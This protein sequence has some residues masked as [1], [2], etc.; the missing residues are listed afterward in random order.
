M[1]NEKQ[2]LLGIFCDI[3]ASK[4]AEI[5]LKESNDLKDSMLRTIPFGIDIVDEHGN[6]LFQNK[7]F[8]DVFS[9]K[10]ISCKCW[11]I[12]RDD[13]TQCT[14]CP[15]LSGIQIGETSTFESQGVLG[16]KTFEISHTGMMF[17]GK[18]AMLEIF[19]DIT[20]RKEA[21]KSW[22]ESEERYRSFISQ[23]SE[24]VY[25]FEC[26]QPMDL[27][28]TIEEQVD[29]IYDHMIIAECN[30]A[31]LALYRV[32]D[33]NEM[34]GKGHL[35]FH[36]DRYH[37][38]NREVMG[39]FV[40]NGYRIKDE[41]TEEF[42]SENQLR[43]FSNNSLGIVENNS[44]VRMWGTQIDVTKRIKDERVQQV[45]SAISNAALSEIDMAELIV[46]IRGRKL[47]RMYVS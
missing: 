5:E 21:E 41:I 2:C 32:S 11:E 12:Y 14:D 18:K 27:S 17:Q 43:Y 20:E 42:D 25:R 1:F 19:Q 29:F 39:K 37:P 31:L 30:E 44:L 40:R 3:S 8:E 47:R 9:K 13:K 10:A 33:Q 22:K 34:I 6:I 28:I 36:L 38:V 24:G 15:L 26:D 4:K 16:G 7:T 23:V 45:L 46:F 35:D